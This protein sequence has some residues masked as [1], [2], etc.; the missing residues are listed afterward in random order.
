MAVTFPPNPNVGDTVTD[1]V[2]GATWVWN[3]VAWVAQ[4]AYEGGYLPLSGGT[5]TGPLIGTTATFVGSTYTG[6]TLQGQLLMPPG[7]P[8]GNIY[9]AIGSTFLWN[10]VPA[11]SLNYWANGAAG[12]IAFGGGGFSF[13]TAPTGTA[14]SPISLN[15]S[16]SI[17]AATGYV[18]MANGLSVGNGPITANGSLSVGGA[19]IYIVQP[20]SLW[21][22]V[23]GTAYS[24]LFIDNSNNMVMNGGANRLPGS[25]II[26]AAIVANIYANSACLILQQQIAGDCQISLTV[27]GIR[28]YLMG[29]AESNGY[30]YIFDQ[31]SQNYRIQIDTGGAGYFGGNWEP[32]WTTPVQG[33]LSGYCGSPTAAWGAMYAGSYNPASDPRQKRDMAPAPAGALDKVKALPVINYRLISPSVPR[34]DIKTEL[35]PLDYDQL[36]VGFDATEVFKVHPDMVT[37]DDD[38]NPV[39]YS[40]SDMNALLWQAVQELAAEVQALKEGRS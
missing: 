8:S 31:T 3:G 10:V 17:A 13:Y 18:S 37:L 28:T 27:A 35:P 40:L 7:T 11:A 32:V 2:S 38:K 24:L 9:A 6:L 21:G 36:R 39:A 16:M 12:A 4:G 19:G 34:M 1:P 23:G 26:E 22:T 20:G 14:A 5:L 15:L 29:I 33:N 30:F 25:L